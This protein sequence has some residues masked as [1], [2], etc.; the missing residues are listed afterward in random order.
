M[1]PK[2]I[3]VFG[4]SGQVGRH[5]IRKLTKSNYKVVA[6]TRNIHRKGYILKTQGNP[7]YLEIVELTSFNIEKIESLIESCSVCINLI[8]IL[9]E[10]RKN[11]FE[12]IHNHL[13]SLLS[14]L[15]SKN[16]IEQFIHVSSLGIENVTDSSYAKSKIDGENAVKNNFHQS[17]ILKPSVIYSVDDNFT[18]NFMKLLSRLPFMP[19]YYEGKTKFTPIHVKDI[20]EIIFEVIKRKITGKTIECVGPEELTFKEIIIKILYSIDKKKILIP[21]PLSIAKIT[22]K[23]F[24]KMPKP[25]LTSDQLNL[26]KYDNIVS[27]K[28]ITNFDLGIDAN[29]VFGKEIEKYSFNWRT[30]GQFSK[31]KSSVIK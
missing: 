20:V 3:L 12:N 13:P 5:L 23:I 10:K 15:A 16:K 19:L 4:A 8:G 17:I 27:G 7:G 31:K 6:V 18:T 24:E 28:Y 1:K 25:L 22:A 14:K 26:L 29:R 9:Y 21:I 11:E 2:E 30:G